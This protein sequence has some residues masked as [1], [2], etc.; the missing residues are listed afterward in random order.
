[1]R[2]PSCAAGLALLEVLVALVLLS[3]LVVGYLRLFQGGHRLFARSREWSDAVG[4]ATD[5]MERAKAAPVE[6]GPHMLEEL[7]E[8]W[9]REVTTSSWQPGIGL[10][11]V[12]VTLPGGGRLELHRLRAEASR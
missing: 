6:E 2:R 7:P 1:M 5:A 4:Y 8:G 10:V 9:G 12:R 3:L 11:T